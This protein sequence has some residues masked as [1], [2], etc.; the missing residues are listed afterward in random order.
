MRLNQ[1]RVHT[2]AFKI[3]QRLQS[4]KHLDGIGPSE[5]LVRALEHAITEELT[6]EDRLNAEVREL[7]KKFDAE[8]QSGK[9]DYQKMFT[10]VKQK[11]VR[12][13][14]IVL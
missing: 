13:R 11:L 4:Q 8:F 9:A 6:V 3:L 14:S 1:E 2:I 12:E 7:L 5:S 10:M